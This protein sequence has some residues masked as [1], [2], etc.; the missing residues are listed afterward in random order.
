[1]Y[2]KKLLEIHQDVL[3]I[4]LFKKT[5]SISIVGLRGKERRERGCAKLASRLF[6]VT[7]VPKRASK[8]T[9]TKAMTTMVDGCG[10]L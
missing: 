8:A 10:C 9:T 3:P 4:D 1:M 2:K 5:R 7:L 6:S